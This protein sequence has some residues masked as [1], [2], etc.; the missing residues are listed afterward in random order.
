MPECTS[1]ALCLVCRQRIKDRCDGEHELGYPHLS[2]SQ[3]SHDMGFTDHEWTPENAD[4]N[5][6]ARVRPVRDA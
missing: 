6:V 2:P 1:T 5:Q 4:D 3:G